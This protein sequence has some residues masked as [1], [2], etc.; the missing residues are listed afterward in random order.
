MENSDA[1]LYVSKSKG[2]RT[3]RFYNEILEEVPARCHELQDEFATAIDN[4]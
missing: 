2:R 4:G 1:A 3:Y